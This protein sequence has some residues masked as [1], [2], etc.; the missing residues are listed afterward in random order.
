MYTIKKVNAERKQCLCNV[1]CSEVLSPQTAVI[2]EEDRLFFLKHISAAVEV[3]KLDGTG[4]R[5]L[6]E[7]PKL[8]LLRGLAVDPVAR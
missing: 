4:R 8:A 6:I 7:Y 5:V 3:A 1:V 2:P